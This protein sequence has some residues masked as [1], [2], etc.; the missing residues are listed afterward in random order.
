M[1][2]YALQREHFVFRFNIQQDIDW[3]NG[4]GHYSSLMCGSY[5]AVRQIARRTKN[6]LFST[7]DTIQDYVYGCSLKQF[8]DKNCA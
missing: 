6:V 2:W 5:C 4:N 8:I 3:F 1:P 7:I